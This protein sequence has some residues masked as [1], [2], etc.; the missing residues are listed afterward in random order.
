[1]NK[2]RVGAILLGV[3]T[4]FIMLPWLVQLVSSSC[5]CGDCPNK[6]RWWQCPPKN[7]DI[8]RPN[9]CPPCPPQCPDISIPACPACPPSPPTCPNPC[10][11]PLPAPAP[12]P[13]PTAPP[14][15]LDTS[16]ATT[17]TN[18][19]GSVWSI[20]P[21]S[22]DEWGNYWMHFAGTSCL[23]T[24]KCLTVQVPDTSGCTGTVGFAFMEAGDPYAAASLR[25]DFNTST[26]NTTFTTG[27]GGWPANVQQTIPNLSSVWNPASNLIKWCYVSDTEITLNVNGTDMGSFIHSPFGIGVVG[28]D[29]AC[30]KTE[31][32]AQVV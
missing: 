24:G 14:A 12:A 15:P 10:P 3:L 21:N 11:A 18:A 8:P 29:A 31:L 6:V 28:I 20:P 19:C 9:P 16:N 23:V 30:I 17:D 2:Y 27:I 32:Y 4:A 7:R 13:A 26:N 25:F 22:I 1:M 5:G